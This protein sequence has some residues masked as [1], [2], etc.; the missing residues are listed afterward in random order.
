MSTVHL[1]G[2]ARK[3]SKTFIQR[4]LKGGGTANQ[5]CLWRQSIHNNLVDVFY[6]FYRNIVNLRKNIYLSIYLSMIDI[7]IHP[8]IHPFYFTLG[9]NKV[10]YSSS[11]PVMNF[12]FLKINQSNFRLRVST[13]ITKKNKKQYL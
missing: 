3:V 1:R 2:A 12:F 5:Q 10:L 9:T 4:M 13:H 7:S 8:S 11:P 6:L